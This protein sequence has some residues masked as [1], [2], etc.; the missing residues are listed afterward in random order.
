MD[1]AMYRTTMLPRGTKAS[2]A[3]KLQDYHKTMGILKLK[4]YMLRRGCMFG[5]IMLDAVMT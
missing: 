5:L 1:G 4:L 2:K 3:F